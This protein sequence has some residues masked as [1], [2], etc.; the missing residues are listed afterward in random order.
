MAEELNNNMLQS[1][2]GNMQIFISED[3]MEVSLVLKKPQDPSYRHSLKAV[4]DFIDA[5]GLKGEIDK[6]E[7]TR[8]IEESI[9]GV[10]TVVLKGLPVK[11]GVDAYFEYFFHNQDKNGKPRILDDGTVDYT[12]VHT[13]GTVSEGDLIAKYHQSVP[14]HFGYNVRGVL[15]KPDQPKAYPVP[16]LL[17]VRYDQDTY[18]YYATTDGKASATTAR[19][20]VNGTLEIKRNVTIAYGNIC[21]IGDVNIVGDVDAGIDIFA[22]GSVN[23]TGTVQGSNIIAGDDVTIK[24][25]VIGKKD[26]HVYCGGNLNVRF[27]QYV[28]VVA[29]G[30][31]TVNSILDSNIRCGGKL[32]L[33]DARGSVY[34]GKIYAMRGI[35]G[36]TFG[37]EKGFE[38]Y[39]AVGKRSEL[40]TERMDYA[41]EI[42]EL[43]NKIK[44]INGRELTITNKL[45][46]MESTTLENT[47]HVIRKNKA[48]TLAEKKQREAVLSSI[49]GLF[50]DMSATSFIEGVKFFPG[51]TVS[52]D[53]KDLRLT[54]PAARVTFKRNAD[55]VYAG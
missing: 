37:N 1:E 47:L 45:K 48:S 11:Q 29:G 23:I 35:T 54:E 44:G 39:L 17:G 28:E 3:E 38:T 50:A 18:S 51:V 2:D 20:E 55:G 14:G 5:N 24:G 49:D 12:S 52:V 34:G 46:E 53:M 9:Y 16:Q 22:S 6:D 40:L 7:I 33:N 31:I 13:V 41:K 10:R 43:D 8:M 36:Q 42:E 4:L 21:F 19:I 30:D 25:G 32:M 26:I 27:I 15:I